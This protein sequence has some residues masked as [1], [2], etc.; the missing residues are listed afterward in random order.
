MSTVEH[1]RSK[2]GNQ[3]NHPVVKS[4]QKPKIFLQKIE[5]PK[6]LSRQKKETQKEESKKVE[7][8]QKTTKVEVKKENESK[9][10]EIAKGGYKEEEEIRNLLNNDDEFKKQ[11]EKKFNIDSKN[12]PQAKLLN[13]TSKVDISYGTNQIQVKKTKPG[14]FGQVHRS[15]ISHL[16]E[17]VKGLFPIKDMLKDLCELPVKKVNGKKMCDK[18]KKVKKLSED[19]YT[20]EELDKLIKCFEDNKRKIVEY[21]F[22]GSNSNSKPDI[23]V[24]SVYNG[25]KRDKIIASNINDIIDQII[26]NPVKIRKSQTVIEIGDSFS[27][28][29]KGG[30][31][32]KDVANQF[33]FKLVPTKLSTEKA[34]IT[35]DI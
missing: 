6:P 13:D 28:Q 25:K 2:D 27:F 20:K 4:N 17:N 33:Q 19:N 22:L 10:R 5:I 15:W 18:T 21:A 32:G 11:I 9:G 34:L 31:G 16:I 3:N 30:D 29:R 35:K 23:F 24:V 8:K 14:Q 7:K 12:N 26:Q 1:T